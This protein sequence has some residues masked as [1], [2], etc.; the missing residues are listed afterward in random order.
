MLKLQAEFG[1]RCRRR[2]FDMMLFNRRH[3]R[4]SMARFN[5]PGMV[6][7]RRFLAWS[8]AAFAAL[9]TAQARPLFGSSLHISSS[10]A[11]SSDDYY[12]K[13]GVEPI[14]NAAGTYTYLTAAV[15]PPQVQRAVAQAAL[16]PVV[17]KELHTAAGEYLSKRLRCEGALVTS[18]ASAALTLATAACI[19][20]ANGARPEQIPQEVSDMKNEV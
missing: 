2:R 4:D 17:L 9:G 12:A 3:S 20:A 15:M 18:G 5:N 6:S 7:R 14:I 16:H 19:A 13:L 10:P 11:A 1:V 8:Q